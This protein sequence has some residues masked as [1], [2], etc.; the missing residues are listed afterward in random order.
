MFLQ[1]LLDDLTDGLNSFCKD[2]LDISKVLRFER[3]L[4]NQQQ[5]KVGIKNMHKPDYLM[6]ENQSNAFKNIYI[7]FFFSLTFQGK[8]VSQESVKQFYESWISRQNTLSSL[9]GLDTLPPPLTPHDAPSSRLTYSRLKSQASKMSL[10][11]SFSR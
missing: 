5:K 11:S 9:E 1:S 8:E 4:L 7:F 10:G 6:L 2:S 3:A